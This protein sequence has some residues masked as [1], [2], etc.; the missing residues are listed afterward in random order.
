MGA[1]ARALMQACPCG[2][3][4]PY[5]HCCRPYIRG[6]EGAPTAEALMRSRYTAYVRRD[7]NYLLKT[8]H[9]RTR[10]EF[11]ELGGTTW[12]GLEILAA[13]NGQAADASGTVTFAAHFQTGDGQT[14]TM[15]E[16]SRFETLDE[17]WL[18]VTGD[19]D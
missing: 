15:R 9:P 4:N 17:A 2:S 7:S 1:R 13:I 12:L 10:P 8:W 3:S 11:L 6:E 18:Y 19:V 14:V 16:L 5:A